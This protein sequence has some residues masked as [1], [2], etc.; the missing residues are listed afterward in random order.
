MSTKVNPIDLFINFT[1]VKGQHYDFLVEDKARADERKE[2]I[3]VVQDMIEHHDKLFE[4]PI[5]I[6]SR[7]GALEKL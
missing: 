2:I 6:A 1:Q 3:D 4:V 7:D 5:T